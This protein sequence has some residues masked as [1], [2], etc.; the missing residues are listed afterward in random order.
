M[1]GA[2]QPS[3]ERKRRPYLGPVAVVFGLLCVPALAG[4]DA[5]GAAVRDGQHDFDFNVGTWKIHVE[6]L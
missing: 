5:T 2:G 1:S 6:R 3:T 4:E